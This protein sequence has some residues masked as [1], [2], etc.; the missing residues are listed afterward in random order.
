MCP[1]CEL[2]DKRIVEL[3]AELKQWKWKCED[4]LLTLSAIQVAICDFK[5]RDSCAKADGSRT[6]L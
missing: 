1:E 3:E 4:V 2:K 5:V 6:N